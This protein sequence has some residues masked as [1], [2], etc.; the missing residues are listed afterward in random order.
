MSVVALTDAVI[1]PLA[2][3]IELLNALVAQLTVLRLVL[4]IRCADLAVKQTF[5]AS[6]LLV[7]ELD[8]DLLVLGVSHGGLVSDGEDSQAEDSKD[9]GEKHVDG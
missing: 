8:L 2:M 9:D 1:N 5:N 3:V 7:E 6:R 4:D